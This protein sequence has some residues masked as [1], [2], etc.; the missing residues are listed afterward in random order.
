MNSL[1]ATNRVK[2]DGG[3]RDSMLIEDWLDSM[4]FQV[5]EPW[6]KQ[7]DPEF[8]LHKEQWLLSH[9]TFTFGTRFLVCKHVR[10]N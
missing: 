1:E 4:E 10:C 5:L 6:S 2:V 7:R 8:H 9:C 3:I